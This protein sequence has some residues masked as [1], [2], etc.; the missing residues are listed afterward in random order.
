M[1]L[2][3]DKIPFGLQA[4]ITHALQGA[5]HTE[6]VGNP[7]LERIAPPGHFLLYHLLQM[8][9]GAIPG[10]WLIREQRCELAFDLHCMLSGA[11]RCK[12]CAVP[13]PWCSNERALQHP[14]FMTVHDLSWEVN[15]GCTMQPE[16]VFGR[17]ATI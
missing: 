10:L 3:K 9:H 8:A 5:S 15:T 6:S 1:L 2:L 4:L 16:S 12:L 13:G 11:S 14:L 17:R 7:P